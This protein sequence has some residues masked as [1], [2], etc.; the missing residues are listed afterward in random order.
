MRVSHSAV[1]LPDE[2]EQIAAAPQSLPEGED[3]HPLGSCASGTVLS[4]GPMVSTLK[5]GVRVAV[6][7]R[8]FVYHAGMLVVPEQL[9]VELPKKVNQEEGAF[10]GIGA[11]ALNL[12][13]SAGMQLGETALIF[14]ADLLGF[15]IAQIARS[16]G[17][18]PILVEA[19]DFRLKKAATLG[20]PHNLQPDPEL[21]IRTVDTE[22]DGLGADAAFITRPDDIQSFNAAAKLLR[23]G[24]T[25]VLCAE[26]YQPVRLDEVT[27]KG[28]HITTAKDAAPLDST[29][30]GREIRWTHR[31]NMGCFCQ[32][33]AERRVQVS[34]LVTDRSPIDR[35]PTAYEKARRNPDGAIGMVFTI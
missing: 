30:P 28:L 31:D 14:G 25:I 13:R 26:M 17:V 5:A 32:L 27:A 16:A 3:G 6:T 9:V 29:S 24:G 21:V 35:A 15:L 10:T 19:S 7:G 2:L 11:H 4:I 34:P 22:T 1:T 20:I 23:P 18:I 12:F 33:L 8:P